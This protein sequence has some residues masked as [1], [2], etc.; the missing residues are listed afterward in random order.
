LI[1]SGAGL[2]LKGFG[3]APQNKFFK[4]GGG[5]QTALS[6]KNSNYEKVF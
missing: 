1:F 6:T 4:L 5:K 2:M 3:L